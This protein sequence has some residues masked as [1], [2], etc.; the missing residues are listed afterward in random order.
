MTTTHTSTYYRD[1]IVAKKM[2]PQNWYNSSPAA[3][4][5]ESSRITDTEQLSTRKGPAG[6]LTKIIM[7]VAPLK[8]STGIIAV[9]KSSAQCSS[10]SSTHS[11]TTAATESTG[12]SFSTTMS[13]VPT[14]NVSNTER[15]TRRVRFRE[16]II[17]KEYTI[18]SRRDYTD[19]EIIATW[20]QSEE[21]QAITSSCCKQVRMIEQG[22]VLRDKK[23]CARGL[24]VH[25]RLASM[26]KS[27]NKRLA[28]DAVLLE[29]DEQRRLGIIDAETIAE[30]YIEVSSSSLLWAQT[31]GMRDRKAAEEHLDD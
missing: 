3:I 16:N 9:A 15:R 13:E 12:S 30:R 25:T 22:A 4:V 29:Q 27:Q 31:V 2:L 14:S 24:E 19:A 6:M 5:D 10:E 21:Y 7:S 28:W 17:S 26:V 23:Y 11:H 1:F 18:L 20:S 8:A